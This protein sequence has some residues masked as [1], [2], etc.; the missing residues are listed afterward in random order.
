MV[1]VAVRD[2]EL[3]ALIGGRLPRPRLYAADIHKLREIVKKE[4]PN[5]VLLD[6]QL[7]GSRWRA[8]D[9]IPELLK[10]SPATAFIVITRSPSVAE[11][12]EM[13]E[14]GA[15]GYVDRNDPELVKKVSGLVAL[16]RRTTADRLSEHA[17]RKKRRS[18]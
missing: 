18:H 5:V 12:D 14:L 13:Q 17:S 10:V 1:V 6:V 4:K 8:V 7:G 11:V 15:C 2:A 9:D 3:S 16:S